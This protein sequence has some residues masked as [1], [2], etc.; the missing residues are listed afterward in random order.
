MNSRTGIRLPL[1][2][3]LIVKRF[4]VVWLLP[5][6]IACGGTTPA[7][8]DGAVLRFT[9]LAA[10][11]GSGESV[12]AQANQRRIAVLATLLGPDPCR[13]LDGEIDHRDREVTLR[14]FIRPSSAGVCVQVVGRFAYEAV[15]EGLR[16]GRYH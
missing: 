3:R 5:F 8:P 4:A 1:L 15:I 10:E 11:P 6:V 14:V 2:P 12:A 9:P 16:P 13:T 7:A